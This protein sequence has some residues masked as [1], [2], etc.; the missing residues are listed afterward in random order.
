MPRN[1]SINS[2]IIFIVTKLFD[3]PINNRSLTY[4]Y[5]ILQS[6]A[7]TAGIIWNWKSPEDGESFTITEPIS[8]T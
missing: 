5:I 2:K 8:H 1:K 6:C 3:S 7:L 4:F